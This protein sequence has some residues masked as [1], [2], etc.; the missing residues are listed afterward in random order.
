MI[1]QEV[2]EVVMDILVAE[3]EAVMMVVSVWV[4]LAVEAAD[5]FAQHVQEFLALH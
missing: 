1:A 5:T 3:E 4:V 2:A